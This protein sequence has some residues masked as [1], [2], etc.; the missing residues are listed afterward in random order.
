MSLL[1]TLKQWLTLEESAAYLSENLGESVAVA[2]IFRLVA[3]GHIELYWK[4]QQAD[5]HPMAL[6][7]VPSFGDAFAISCGFFDSE[8]REREAEYSAEAKQSGPLTT[9]L[10]SKVD[11]V[12]CDGKQTV[13]TLD[14][15][16]R[17][18]FSLSVEMRKWLWAS[19]VRGGQLYNNLHGLWIGDSDGQIWCVVDY[20]DPALVSSGDLGFTLT[21]PWYR[22]TDKTPR[23]SELLI[24]KAEIESLVS[25]FPNTSTE[26]EQPLG[27]RERNTLLNIIGGLLELI[28]GE[29]PSG[30]KL[31]RFE[32]Q[33]AVIDGLLARYEGKAG[34]KKRTLEEKFAKA[35]RQLS[36]P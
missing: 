10:F 29:S 23:N 9:K 20:R 32:S 3:D 24:S 16:Y 22:P 17:L 5:A 6:A 18:E 35:K 12:A 21:D 25:D 1:S 28:L 26:P 19:A 2:D 13:M 33:A 11:W 7:C 8:W 34:I 30:Q 14:G 15:V 31:S 36:E 27:S 4:A